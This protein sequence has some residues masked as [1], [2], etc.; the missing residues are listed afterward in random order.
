MKPE[1]W[2]GSWTP[3][4]LSLLCVCDHVLPSKSVQSW[5][6]FAYS[7]LWSCGISCPRPG[8]IQILLDHTCFWFQSL[9]ILWYHHILFL[10]IAM[11]SL[12]FSAHRKLF[13]SL[14]VQWVMKVKR[15]WIASLI[16]RDQD[17]IDLF[18]LKCPC[19]WSCIWGTPYMCVEYGGNTLYI[20]RQTD[21]R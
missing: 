16:R 7:A 9:L 15:N 8:A 21:D 20:C 2:E 19:S 14:L 1:S 11:T 10:N 6:L 5:L 4:N 17:Y 18:L 3:D 12:V 13:V